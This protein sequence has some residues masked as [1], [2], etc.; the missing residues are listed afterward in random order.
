MVVLFYI[1]LVVQQWAVFFNVLMQLV[2]RRTSTV[3][4]KLISLEVE[5]QLCI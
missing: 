1:V 5:I 4:R 3:I 2:L